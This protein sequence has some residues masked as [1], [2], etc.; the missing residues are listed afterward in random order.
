MKHGCVFH[1]FTSRRQEETFVLDTRFLLRLCAL[2][3]DDDR[4][5]SPDIHGYLQQEKKTTQFRL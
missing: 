1:F 5:S 3:Q 2:K 4:V